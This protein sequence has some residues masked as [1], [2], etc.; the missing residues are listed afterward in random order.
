MADSTPIITT[1]PEFV[2][3]KIYLRPATAE[4]MA[5]SYHWYLLSDPSTL[6]CRPVTVKTAAEFAEE[7]KKRE[8]TPDDRRFMIVRRKTNEP[9]GWVRYFDLNTLNRSAEIGIL[10]DPDARKEGYGTEAIRLLCR[11]LFRTRGLNKVHAFTAVFNTGA[12][13]LM[14]KCGF[15]LDGTLR[16]HYFRQGEYHDGLAYSLLYHEFER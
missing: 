5:N 1:A 16:R 8:L 4:D 6:T 10:L 14:E 2:G 13:K 3:D 9:V 12:V 15:H 11:H 7:Y